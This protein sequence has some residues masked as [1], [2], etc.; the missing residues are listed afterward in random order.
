MNSNFLQPCFF[1]GGG[2][3]KIPLS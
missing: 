2:D 3:I 1:L